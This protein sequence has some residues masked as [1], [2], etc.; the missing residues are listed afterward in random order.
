MS[1]EEYILGNEVTIRLGFFLGVFAVMAVWEIIAPR[2]RLHASKA[3]RWA[4]AKDIVST[5]LITIPGAAA[6][7][8]L[9]WFGAQV[10]V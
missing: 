8:I 7:G 2:R 4:K 1:V 10:F 5:W 9:A 3:V 6:V